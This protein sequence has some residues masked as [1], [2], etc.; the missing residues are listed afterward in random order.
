MKLCVSK[1][2]SGSN[3]NSKNVTRYSGMNNSV[4]KE[5]DRDRDKET[6]LVTSNALLH[7]I[8]YMHL[9]INNQH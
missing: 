1:F 4:D 5:R 2:Q 7:F 6:S 9:H 8:R 3:S